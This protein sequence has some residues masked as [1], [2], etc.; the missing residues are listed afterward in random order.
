MSEHV[1]FEKKGYKAYIT[2][3]KP[4]KLNALDDSMY[5]AILQHLEELDKDPNIRVVILKGNG[6]A[7]SS[8]YDIQAETDLSIPPMTEMMNFR[9]GSNMLRWKIWNLSKPVICQVHGYCLG[10][11]CELM[12]PCDYVIAADD[13]VIGEPEIQ[14]GSPPVFLM[15]PWLTGLRKGKELMFTGEKISGIEAAACG[16]V[17]KSVPVQ[18]LEKEVTAVANRLIKMPPE[19]LYIQKLGINRQ[20]EIMGMKSGIDI[21]L[22]MSMYFRFFKTEE[23]EMFSK[24]SAEQGVKAAL[25]WRDKHFADMEERQ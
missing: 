16:L 6:R 23:V 22:D 19:I 21:W 1:L 12:L 24:I 14:F 9:D 17:T 10:G 18:D 2:L 5:R 25:K 20:F 4:E 13:A 11:A 8:G 15:I 7:F 3:N